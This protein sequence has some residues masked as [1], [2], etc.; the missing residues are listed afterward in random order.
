MTLYGKTPMRKLSLALVLLLCGAAAF[1]QRQQGRVIHLRGLLNDY[2]PSTVANGPYEM[3]GRWD[4]AIDLLS[5]K[6]DLVVEMNMETSDYGTQNGVVDP[7]NPATRGAHTHHIALT[8]APITWNMTGCPAFTVKTLQGF[9][10]TGTV[11]LLTGN[12]SPAAFETT[13]P[14]SVIQVCVTGGDFVGGSVPYSN[15]TMTFVPLPS[16]A[17]SPAAKHFGPQPIHGV[18]TDVN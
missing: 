5:G 11:S 9:Q 3:R 4:I 17:P 8:A 15:L 6:A 2:G 13:P 12:G 14:S 7:T 10:F 16:G 18:V 1:A